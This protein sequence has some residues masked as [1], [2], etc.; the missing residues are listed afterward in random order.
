M[1]VIHISESEKVTIN[2][3]AVDLGQIDLLVDQGFY[4]NRTDF[5]RQSIRQQLTVHS[6]EIK[7]MTTDKYTVFGVVKFNIDELEGLKQGN[8]EVDI[9]LIGTLIIAEDVPLELVQE[10]F[11][12]VKVFG[13]IKARPDIK[14]Y[15]QTLRDH[16]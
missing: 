13:I 1:E 16:S 9:R 11:T 14:S 2:L 7:Q 6:A 12:S 15:L 8:R 5:I 4:S 10:T 3:G